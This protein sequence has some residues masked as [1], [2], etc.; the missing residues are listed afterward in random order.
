MRITDIYRTLYD[1]TTNTPNP[2][3]PQSL[4]HACIARLCQA[5]L[6][7]LDVGSD[8]LRGIAAIPL[9][10]LSLVPFLGR[11]ENL[12]ET[13]NFFLF[14]SG[15]IFS[16]AFKHSLSILNPGA[17]NS[18]KDSAV[19]I[20]ELND[21]DGIIAA[22]VR[23]RLRSMPLIF[24]DSKDFYK[25]HVLARLLVPTTRVFILA[26]RVLDLGIA[27]LAVPLAFISAGMIRNLNNLAYRS[28]LLPHAVQD[29]HRTVLLVLNP[30]RP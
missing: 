12:N 2:A 25:K 3:A 27:I 13:S 11:S 16:H 20:V 26:A 9:A 14:Q 6:L 5:A 24:E 19:P 1:Q 30:Y 28:L 21:H 15:L 18:S 7:P 4:K 29:I 22:Y 17:F 10:S 8:L 23:H